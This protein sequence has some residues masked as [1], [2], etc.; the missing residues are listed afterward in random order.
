[1]AK[2]KMAIVALLRGG[3]GH[4]VAQL[5]PHLEEYFDLEYISYKYGLPGDIVTLDDPAIAANI[6]K[7]PLFA[8]AYN[9]YQETVASLG[10]VSRFIKEEK[11]DIL[12][13]HIGT[14]ARETAYWSISLILAAKRMGVKILF[15]FHDV[16][17]FEE[18]G[19]GR[20]LLKAFY[21]LCDGGTVGGEDEMKKLTSGFGFDPAK[22][23]IARHGI[24][25]IF[26]FNKY[27]RESARKH[28]GIG[29]DKKVILNFGI[30]R[31]YKGF[32]DC[33]IA[34]PKILEKHPEAYLYLSAGIRVGD[35]SKQLISLCKKEKLGKS[36][37]LV[38]DFV[39]SDEIEPIFKAADIVALPYKQ[40]SQSGILNLA[41][42]F[43]K[44][45]IL[46]NL[47]VEAEEISNCAGLIV[48]PDRPE[49]IFKA[50]TKL[51]DDEALYK[52]LVEGSSYFLEKN[53]WVETAKQFKLIVDKISK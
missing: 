28:L 1:M 44:P 32:D 20:E 14:I 33:I 34:M 13:F 15:T 39:P 17:P 21:S 42:N 5:T 50:V 43:R 24:Y 18:Y 19:G 2:P 47:F 41:L 8:I 37:K 45:V 29:L 51:L 52:K 30:L 35:H 46:S 31:D 26:N 48:E 3:I 12:N 40:V 9:S 22:L 53:I 6:K 7:K 10:E 27:T 36:A 4:Y 23:V 16:E 49:Q 38:F 25:T 11:I